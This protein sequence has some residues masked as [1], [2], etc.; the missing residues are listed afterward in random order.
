MT[1]RNAT[2][3]ATIIIFGASGDLTKRK[4][5]PALYDLYLK[6]ILPDGCMIIGTSRTP[7]SHDAFRDEMRKAVKDVGSDSNSSIRWET[8]A[9]R[10]FYLPGDLLQQELHHQL[11]QFIRDQC[12]SGLSPDNRL[13]YLAVAPQFHE[14][15]IIHLGSSYSKSDSVGWR[16]I[17]IEKPFGRDLLTA[18]ALNATLHQYFDEKQ[19]FRIDHYL[20]KETVQNILVFRFGNAIFEPL[21]NRNYID[22]VQITVAE[23]LGIEGRGSYY[24]QAGVVRDIVQNHMLQLLAI[25]AMEPPIVY[26]ANALRDEKVKVLRAIRAFGEDECLQDVV[27]GQYMA[28]SLDEKDVIDYRHEKNVSSSSRT[29]TFVA[30]RLYI[31]NWRWQGVPFYLRSGK[32]LAAKFTEINVEFK[33]PPFLLFAPQ[34]SACV[35]PNILGLCIQP[36]EGIHLRFQ[37][38]VPGAGLQMIPTSLEFHY[39]DVVGNTDLPDAYERLLLDALQGDASLFAR[40]DEIELAWRIIDPIAE[41]WESVATNEPS[42]Y[43]AGS[44]GPEAAVEFLSRHGNVWHQMCLHRGNQPSE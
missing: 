19:I 13:Y 5:L 32:R 22:N 6:G 41:G 12:H 21:W 33:C 16:R 23:K 7:Y 29:P 11:D 39:Q 27:M 31:D 25:I 10:L 37:A 14:P 35:K 8:F 15:M 30:L 44:W 9:Q 4:L 34:D 18:R 42:S 38:K 26:E 3:P 40:S 36:D 20:G 1:S 28:G 2:E 43:A 24:E 17:V